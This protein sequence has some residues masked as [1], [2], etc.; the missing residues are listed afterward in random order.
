MCQNIKGLKGYNKSLLKPVLQTN[1]HVLLSRLWQQDVR[2]NSAP[3]LRTYL[4]RS[5]KHLCR[6][7]IKLK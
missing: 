4:Y 7:D 3:V 6:Q 1:F 2:H 5:L